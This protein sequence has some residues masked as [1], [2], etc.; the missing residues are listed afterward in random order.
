MVYEKPVVTLA[1]LADADANW[2]PAHYEQA[3]LGGSSG[4]GNL[5]NR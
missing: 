5:F 2:R 4:E 3:L 1:V